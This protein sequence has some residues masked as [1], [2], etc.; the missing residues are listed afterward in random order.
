M[1][2]NLP[3]SGSSFWTTITAEIEAGDG[4]AELLDGDLRYVALTLN[5][6]MEVIRRTK[7]EFFS[8]TVARA[9]AD[10]RFRVAINGSFY[11]VTGAGKRDAFV[12]HDPVDAS[13]TLPIGHVVVGGS[14]VIGRDSNAF[15]LAFNAAGASADWYDTGGPQNSV[16]PVTAGLG[17]LNPIIIDG[18]PYGTSNLY[19][20]GVKG[21]PK[22]VGEPDAEHRPFLIRRSNAGYTAMAGKSDRVGKVVVAVSVKRRR[23]LVIVQADGATTGVSVDDLRDKLTAVG[24][25]EHAVSLDGSDSALMTVD[26]ARRVTQGENK[27]ET[28]T[29]GLGFRY[30]RR[31]YVFRGSQYVRYS[32]DDDKAD[33]GVKSLSAWKK[34]PAE[35]KKGI[36]AAVPWRNGKFYFFRGSEYVRYNGWKDEVDQGPHSIKGDGAGKFA[37]NG[38]PASFQSG[39]DSSVNWGNGKLYFTKGAEWVEYDVSSDKVTQGPKPIKG[40]WHGVPKAFES[41]FDSMLQWI[42]GNVYITRGDQYVGYS[43]KHNKVVSGP[44]TVSSGWKGM[45]AGWSAGFDAQLFW[46]ELII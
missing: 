31:A 28:C 8:D 20:S 10:R 38:F 3:I 29:I 24:D 4:A 43:V 2:K 32:V 12:G 16:P 7:E 9:V 11:D 36:D 18:L 13:E 21:T 42:D 40:H 17:G 34:M 39:V 5:A 46:G 30:L 27:D 33:T 45:P 15:F 23:I 44:G 19:S 1:A 14:H 25:I 35:F 37:W 41:G 26:G 22:L 6:E